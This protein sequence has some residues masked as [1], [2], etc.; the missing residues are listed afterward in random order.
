[1]F[2]YITDSPFPERERIT[3]HIRQ[4]GFF[5]IFANM[6]KTLTILAVLLTAA[7]E[8]CRFA[9]LPGQMASGAAAVLCAVTIT[10]IF[11]PL[12]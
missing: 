7:L 6:R 8:A 10:D 2:K 9:T 5:A 4:V 1:M 11:V 12:S 3:P